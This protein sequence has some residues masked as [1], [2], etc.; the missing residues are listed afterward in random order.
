MARLIELHEIDEFSDVKRIPDDAISQ[1]IISNVRKLYERTEIEPFLRQIL[2]DPNVT[3]HGSTEIADILTHHLHVEGEQRFAGFV[4]KGKSFNKVRSVDVA[5]QFNKLRQ[6][7]DLRLIVFLAVGHIHDDA[8]RDFVQEATDADYD[9]LIIDVQDCARLFLAYQKICPKDGTPYDDAGTCQHGHALDPAI[10]RQIDV[11][12]GLRYE[13][14]TLKDLSHGGAKRYRAFVV[15]DQHYTK[16][17]IR[18]IIKEVTANLKGTNYYRDERTEA[19]W[20]DTEAHVVWLFIAFDLQDTRI[21]NWVCRTSWID[22]S[23]PENM[24]PGP[25]NGDD[26]VGEI[27]VSWNEDYD[28]MKQFYEQ[29]SASKGKY[30]QTVQP[31]LKQMLDFGEQAEGSFSKYKDGHLS[32]SDFISQMHA[33]EPTVSKLYGESGNV[34]FPP[35]DCKDYDDACH[36]TFATVHN[37]FLYYSPSGLNTRPQ[38]N[39]DWLMQDAVKQ[40]DE[41]RQRL[42]F[43]ERKLH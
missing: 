27:D 30:L 11:R 20:G 26:L 39:R 37:M 38:R 16:D 18:D 35:Q 13:V 40:F 5:H 2:Y 19:H 33:L 3:P 12:E 25:L 10:R 43:E 34:P 15:L 32:E 28:S 29:H 8:K 6:I 17:T 9:Y 31:I 41:E 24:Q 4:L 7:A 21:A 23:L 1:E 36:C 14:V 42:K 22:R